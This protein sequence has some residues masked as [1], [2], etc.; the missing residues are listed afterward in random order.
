M[1]LIFDSKLSVQKNEALARLVQ[2]AR[3]AVQALQ[4][5]SSQWE[6]EGYQGH[7]SDEEIAAL[8]AALIPFEGMY[9][10]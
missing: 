9:H 4:S 10:K 8:Q 6:G 3:Q 7:Y 5:E 1:E 2:A